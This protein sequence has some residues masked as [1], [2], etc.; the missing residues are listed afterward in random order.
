MEALLTA[1]HFATSYENTESGGYSPTTFIIFLVFTAISLVAMWR[2]FEKAKQ[3]G[4]TVFIPIYN[5]SIQ[6]RIVGRPGW[7]LLLYLIPVV[8]VI[9]TIVVAIDLAKAFG[10]STTFGVVGLWL[11]N[12]IGILILGFGDAKYKGVPKH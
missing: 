10:K 11:F 12:I 4:W 3:P 9:V 8:N 1:T 7:W 6:L 5:L 2:V